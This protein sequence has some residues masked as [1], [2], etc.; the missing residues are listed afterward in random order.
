M[1]IVQG[2]E[3]GAAL[4]CGI[5]GGDCRHEGGS[6]R[7]QESHRGVACR[8]RG[9]SDVW[10]WVIGSRSLRQF[11]QERADEHEVAAAASWTQALVGEV[12]L[13]GAG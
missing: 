2:E 6:A 11:G 1:G 10:A 4:L 8:A 12:C 9:S 13:I 7:T 3:Q 5:V